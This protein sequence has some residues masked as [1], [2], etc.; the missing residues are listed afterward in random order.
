MSPSLRSDPVSRFLLRLPGGD[1]YPV[2]VGS[3]VVAEAPDLIAALRVSRCAVITDSHLEAGHAR[4]V[5]DLLR[6]RGLPGDLFAFPAGEIHK[7]RA[8]KDAIEDAM[9]EAGCGRDTAVVA[10]GGGVT[11]DLAGF[12]A[13]TFMRGIPWLQVPTSLIAMADASIGGKV[14]V[15]HPKGKNLIGAFHHPV[16]VLA[17]PAYLATL[18]A[19][20]IRS[21]LAEIV[22]AGMIADGELFDHLETD[23]PRLASLDREAIAAPLARA[24]GVKVSIVIED[25]REDG[26]RVALNF[27][28][29]I[30]HALERLSGW[31]LRHGEAISIGMAAEAL[32]AVEAG[33]L[34][35]GAARRLTRLLAVLGLPVHLPAGADPPAILAA[36]ATDKKTR[37]GRLR[38]AL[39]GSVGSIARTAGGFAATVPPGTVLACLEAI[40]S[41]PGDS[42][43]SG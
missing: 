22:K 27:G 10:V 26:I 1:A 41:V 40:R 29:T 3:G 33:I 19:G 42:Q 24:V 23:A 8:A 20:E 9:L 18:P 35:E 28:H 25:E 36:A 13:A 4:D 14:G 38:L 12:V 5:L 43:P 2:V 6:S 16:A 34:E 15:D 30:G 39:P 31:S 11:G 32:M 17:D 37:E 7:T 21:G